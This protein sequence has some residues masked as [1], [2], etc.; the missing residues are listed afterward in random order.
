MANVLHQVP[1]PDNVPKGVVGG[2]QQQN[3]NIFI[4]QTGID[5]CE[6]F[7]DGNGTITIP[8]GGVVD[9]N[10]VMFKIPV[11]DTITLE[12]PN[13]AT[14]YWIAVAGLADP[15]RAKFMLVTRPGRWDSAKQGYYL[16][17]GRRTLNWVSLGDVENPP[18]TGAVF[19]SEVK[20]RWIISLKKGWYSVQLRSGLGGGDGE[21]GSWSAAGSGGIASQYHSLTAVVSLDG[22]TAHHI[23]VG[24][25]GQDG[26]AGTPANLFY[27]RRER[28]RKRRRRS[29]IL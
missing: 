11:T 29:F 10:G 9:F 21:R 15:E 16:S 5:T 6:P 17:D 24:G 8:G 22:N 4:L 23:K 19:S 7:D 20:G 13:P 3:K 27:R 1:N 18:T 28:R 14:A 12:K 2:Y 25:N 26:A